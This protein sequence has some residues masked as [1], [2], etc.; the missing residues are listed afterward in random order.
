MK[1]LRT[2]YSVTWIMIFMFSSQVIMAEVVRND[3]QPA[4]PATPPPIYRSVV[5]SDPRPARPTSLPS[6]TRDVVPSDSQPLRPVTLPTVTRDVVPSDSQPAMPVTTPGVR[7]DVVPSDSQPFAP[8]NTPQISPFVGEIAVGVSLLVVYGPQIL[9]TAATIASLAAAVSLVIGTSR[10][11][12]M[13]VKSIGEKLQRMLKMLLGPLSISS[14]MADDGVDQL[15][16]H[17]LQTARFV[18]KSLSTPALEVQNKVGASLMM[19][20]D[21]KQLA[22]QGQRLASQMKQE[23]RS[24]QSDLRKIVAGGEV[25]LFRDGAMNVA[26]SLEA[27]AEKSEAAFSQTLT[28]TKMTS[29]SLERVLSQISAAMEGGPKDATLQELG[30]SGA[31][32]GKQLI[33]GRK[34][35]VMSSRSIQAAKESSQG[36]PRDLLNLLTDIRTELKLYALDN[37]VDPR[38]LNE[39]KQSPRVRGLFAPS[40][41]IAK[42]DSSKQSSPRDLSQEIGFMVDNLSRINKTATDKLAEM[43]SGRSSLRGTPD[44]G[45]SM[46]R[47]VI[48]AYKEYVSITTKTPGDEAAVSAARQKYETLQIQYNRSRGK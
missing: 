17:L 13:L 43:E 38:R 30:L 24:T 48:A 39:A 25:Q 46:Y 19:S 5:P 8:G 27:C 28:N 40:A 34:Y 32:I 2:M 20:K 37:G 29:A 1:K 47:K 3:G 7:R 6:I 44:M 23:S 12:L 18:S 22:C 9:A 26:K 14:G 35:A 10:H 45:D 15:S 36:L 4:K 21:L 42:V 41:S 16:A 33:D 11:S 31:E